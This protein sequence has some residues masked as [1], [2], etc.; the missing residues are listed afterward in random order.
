MR[1]VFML[2]ATASLMAAGGVAVAANSC[3]V[4]ASSLAF[5]AYTPGMGSQYSTSTVGVACTAGA[6]FAIGSSS[7]SSGSF[8]QRLLTG[9]ANPVQYNLYTT[10]AYSTIW[11]DGSGSTGV[12]SGSGLG[13]TTRQLFT[14]YGALPDNAHNQASTPGAYLDTITVVVSF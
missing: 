6:L 9:G 12:F 5:G 4:Q 10:S 14:I 2:A 1:K 3:T 7:G 11:G 13:P 8:T